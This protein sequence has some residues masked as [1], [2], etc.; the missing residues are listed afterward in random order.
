MNNS[1]HRFNS[2]YLVSQFLHIIDS[3]MHMK[4]HA[5]TDHIYIH[6]ISLCTSSIEWCSSL[7]IYAV[8]CHKVRPA[9]CG[10][11]HIY[12]YKTGTCQCAHIPSKCHNLKHT[13]N[14]DT[15]HCGCPN[16][17]KCPHPKKFHTDS[18]NCEC[19][20]IKSYCV[21]PKVFNHRTCTCEY[22]VK[23]QCPSN[24]EFN[25]VINKCEC[26]KSL[27][28]P[29]H[30]TLNRDICKC[31]CQSLDHFCPPKLFD[32]KACTCNESMCS[33]S[34]CPSP[35]VLDTESC[36]CIC[37]DDYRNLCSNFEGF[38]ENT[39]SCRCKNQESCLSHQSFNSATCQ[40]EPRSPET[41]CYEEDASE[42]CLLPRIWEKNSCR[43]VCPSDRKY[44]CS[45]MEELDESTCHCRCKNV[46]K[47][48]PPKIFNS[49]SCQCEL[50]APKSQC[51]EVNNSH[52]C[53]SPKIWDVESCTCICPS[54]RKNLC[55]E[56]EEFDENACHCRC[57]TMNCSPPKMLNS[58][59]CQCDIPPKAKCYRVLPTP[60]SF[61]F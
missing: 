23:Y 59:T 19:P 40:C 48:L 14:G 18:C 37:P 54:D 6:L 3:R 20:H 30:M 33:I 10:S 12:N 11:K 24:Q 34:S 15:C 22:Q 7:Q 36:K 50:P 25:P 9:R 43:C 35:K 49:L 26:L 21:H 55:S 45:D 39:C 42:S 4:W 51:Y 27:Y 41:K 56:L 13:F 53:Q 46:E 58:F 5:Y 17:F 47:C 31:E 16:V 1:N 32:K 29:P 61:G 57:K 38:D 52:F 2:F 8:A 28:C 60:T 44:L